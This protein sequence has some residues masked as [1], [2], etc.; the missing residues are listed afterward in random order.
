MEQ[1]Y[2]VV[3]EIETWADSPAAAARQALE[4]MQDRESHA[5]VF[6]VTDERGRKR[7][8][9]LQ[10]SPAKVRLVTGRRGT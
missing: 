6:D 8:V 10:S 3:W 2:H 5:T 1:K 7:Q 9:D 4:I